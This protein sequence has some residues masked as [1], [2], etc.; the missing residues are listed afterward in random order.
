MLCGATA[1]A[2]P[3]PNPLRTLMAADLAWADTVAAR[4]AVDGH[5]WGLADDATYLH[6]GAPLVRRAYG[7]RTDSGNGRPASAR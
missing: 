4:G 1:A 2:Q 6:A 5:T 7:Y 3:A